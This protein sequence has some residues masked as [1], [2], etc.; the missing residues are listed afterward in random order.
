MTILQ[1]LQ[2]D[3]LQISDERSRVAVDGPLLF[4]RQVAH[5]DV[6]CPLRRR[7]PTV[8]MRTRDDDAVGTNPRG[9]RQ[10]ASDVA[11]RLFGNAAVVEREQKGR[12]FSVVADGERLHPQLL[13]NPD[14]W[15][16]ARGVAC[17]ANRFGGRH[18]A[19]RHADVH[20]VGTNPNTT[21]DHGKKPSN[22]M[23]ERRAIHSG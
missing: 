9:L 2:R 1:R 3:V 6:R 8:R 17:Q 22:G 11:P 20:R 10:P 7:R 21:Q 15:C 12:T 13:F 4:R 23:R 16:L 19:S 5:E 18:V 14:V